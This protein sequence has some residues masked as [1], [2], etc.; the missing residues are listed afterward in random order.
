MQV[1]LTT[2]RREMA[3]AQSAHCCAAATQGVTIKGLVESP[4]ALRSRP[5]TIHFSNSALSIF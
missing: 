2:M 1:L 4:S 3:L 5:R